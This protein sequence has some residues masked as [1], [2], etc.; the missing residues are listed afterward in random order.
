MWNKV[1]NYAEFADLHVLFQKI[2]CI[3]ATLVPMQC[4]FSMSDLFIRQHR[5]MGN[6]LLSELVI[7]V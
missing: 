5:A 7:I 6:K 3:P 2:F 1:R 4:V